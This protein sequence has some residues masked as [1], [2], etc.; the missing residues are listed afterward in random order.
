MRFDKILMCVDVPYF[1]SFTWEI[2]KIEND[3]LSGIPTSRAATL[4]VSED[5][6]IRDQFYNGN[7]K[8]ERAA[9]VLRLAKSWFR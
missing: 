6:V 1:S 5:P 9:V 4:V 3:L 7:I 8:R 2:Y